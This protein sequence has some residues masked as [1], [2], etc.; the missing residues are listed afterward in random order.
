[1]T[2]HDRECTPPGRPAPPKRL[3]RDAIAALNLEMGRRLRRAHDGET[4][5]IAMIHRADQLVEATFTSRPGERRFVTFATLAREWAIA[6]VEPA[7]V[8]EPDEPLSRVALDTTAVAGQLARRGVIR[9]WLAPGIHD[10]VP[11]ERYH[12][13]NVCERPALSAGVIKT[14]LAYSPWHAWYQHPR[15]NPQWEPNVDAKFDLGTAAHELLLKGDDIA[16]W[17]DAEDWR[18]KAAR[19]ARDAARREGKVPLLACQHDGILEMIAAVR[20]QLTRIDATPPL[21]ASGKPEQTLIWEEGGVCCKARCDW[22]HA[23]LS[24]I[25]DLKTTGASGSPHEWPRRVFWGIG[26]DIQSAWYRRGLKAATGRSAAFRFL[27]VEID[28]PYAA[29]VFDLAPSAD[30][31]AQRKIAWALNTWRRCLETGEWPGYGQRVASIELPLW[32]EMAFVERTAWS[33]EIAT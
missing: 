25:D 17:I 8:E 28:P 2:G 22:L 18:T 3:R 27:V 19:D 12:G 30:D 24:A 11:A 15:L 31:I 6:P 13:A 21:L 23:D 33:E 9:R 7:V 14:L 20:E 16:A 5:T 26:G 29:S 10:N 4:A 1:M 32:A